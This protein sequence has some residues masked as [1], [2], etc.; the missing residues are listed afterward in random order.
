NARYVGLDLNKGVLVNSNFWGYSINEM[1]VYGNCSGSN[2]SSNL[3]SNISQ[4]S[5]STSV[6]GT[7]GM[8]LA[9]L[10]EYRNTPSAG[11]L[12][13]LTHLAAFSIMP[14]SGG[15]IDS[16]F[17]V[18]ASWK[19]NNLVGSAH[20]KGVKVIMTV[21]GAGR[22]TYFP[23]VAASS[24]YRTTFAN[25]L[26]NYVV[27]N[28]LDGVDIDWEFP[29]TSTEKINLGYLLSAIKSAMPSGKTVSIAVGAD[30]GGPTMF[31]STVYNNV[32]WV[33]LM[34]YDKW[35]TSPGYEHSP[36][37][38]T[39]DLSS[40]GNHVG[41]NKVVFGVPFYG[42]KD[43]AWGTA[44]TYVSIIGSSTYTG[45]KLN[46]YN[47]NGTATIKYKSDYA[48]SNEYAGVLAW[49]V[50][51]D[52]A[53]NDSRSLLSTIWTSRT[54]YTA[55]LSSSALSS[56]QPLSSISPSSSTPLSSSVGASFAQSSS[57]VAIQVM[58]IIIPAPNTYKIDAG[59]Q[60]SYNDGI[61]LSQDSYTQSWSPLLNNIATK[62]NIPKTGIPFKLILD[63]T[64]SELG[65]EGYKLDV[66]TDSIVIRAKT[67]TGIYYG[68]QSV[69]QLWFS[70]QN[71]SPLSIKDIPDNSW[72]GLMLDIARNHFG[73]EYLKE[74]VDHMAILKLNRFHLHLTDDQ[75]WR[76][77]SKL[78]PKLHTIGSQSSTLGNSGYLTQS[79][80]KNLNAYA[81][82]RG[83][84]IVPEIDM[85]GHTHA[86]K[87]AY[88]EHGCGTDKGWPYTGTAVGFSTL[89]LDNQTTNLFAG[90]IIKELISITTGP[91]IHIGGD[92]VSHS[93]YNTFVQYLDSIVTNEGK[94]MVGWQEITTSNLS[95][96]TI[97]QR[98]KKT[99]PTNSNPTI[100]SN[101]SFAY[102]D[103]PE[104]PSGDGL[105]WCTNY[106]SD[107]HVYAL[108]SNSIGVE[109]ALWGELLKDTAT[110]NDRLFPRIFSLGEA[111]WTKSGHKDW[112]DFT[113][114]LNYLKS[115]LTSSADL[116]VPVSK[117]LVQRNFSSN[118]IW[119]DLNG[120]PVNDNKVPGSYLIRSSNGQWK[121]VL[122][123]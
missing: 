53:V 99:S 46:G 86:L 113:R 22:S 43:N 4:S 91:W 19:L 111:A 7:K 28:N 40:W 82:A 61:S 96:S 90:S 117:N 71:H 115:E 34:S 55:H 58:P 98:W 25:N 33:G 89:C 12:D 104:T 26:K 60:W 3:S 20:A 123:H 9:Y 106:V 52:V 64:D 23:S 112:N 103:H 31:N 84:I 47:Y 39:N 30:H 21:G 105:T 27:A 41:K 93:K 85:P 67:R 77:E 107:Q 38:Y 92:E 74:V 62:Y 109:A 11:Q 63:D 2:S 14:K 48:F 56:S 18:G 75:G 69:K 59:S 94:V 13:K 78:W 54:K 83:V 110:V 35:Y 80:Y 8:V 65:L 10:P 70:K 120:R 6:S 73:L 118:E 1:T 116:I 121:R 122:V 17:V 5:S 81:L 68:I 101:C 36:R 88:P 45:D 102:L 95:N 57:S 97:W 114:R 42:R 49:E 37:S 108:S 44:E 51:Q 16:S 29:D 24:I 100:N 76:I 32:D 87:A 72:R 79:D 119:M 50:G 66:S 15:G